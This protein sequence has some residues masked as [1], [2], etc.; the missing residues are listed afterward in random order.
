[1]SKKDYYSILGVERNA[2]QEQI[3]KAYRKLAIQYHPDKAGEDKA[4]EE[5]FKE[6]AEAYEVLSDETKKSNYDNYGNAKGAGQGHYEEDFSDIRDQF[7]AAFGFGGRANTVRKGAS[8]EV[9]VMLTL[10]EINKGCQ[11]RL[12][13]QKNIVCKSCGGNGSKFG[14]SLTN[15]PR[16]LGHG[17][18]HQRFGH[19]TII[20]T[21]GHCGGH[22]KFITEECEDCHAT[23]MTQVEMEVDV[24]IP[25]GVFEGWYA[26]VDGY[27]HDAKAE[28]SVPGDLV[29]IVQQAPHKDFERNADDLIYRLFLSFPD[30]VLGTKIE[31]PTLENPVAFEIPS[32][33]PAGKVFRLKSRGLP[34]LRRR[35]HTGDML[36]VV[37]VDVPETISDDEKKLL[38]KLR[39]SNNFISKNT[40]KK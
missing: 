8:A 33:T 5:K 37:T 30:I 17:K 19:Q 1:M 14:K 39:K 12:K 22:G 24:N 16:C 3:K 13:Y 35:N 28:K 2:T 7:N 23:G 31:I 21:C 34:S 10:E 27:G 15:C 40:Y 25:A 9:Y 4:A 38:E 29:V 20:H 36:V 11:K 6:V 32:N 26:T 18:M